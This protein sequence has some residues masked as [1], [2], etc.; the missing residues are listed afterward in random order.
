VAVTAGHVLAAAMN[1]VTTA[2]LM[3]PLVLLAKRL[4]YAAAEV[5]KLFTYLPFQTFRQYV[6]RVSTKSPRPHHSEHRSR[7]A[8]F[9][10]GPM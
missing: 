4:T 2:A 6:H 7:G 5:Q 9:W 1:M 10:S 8:M 3:T